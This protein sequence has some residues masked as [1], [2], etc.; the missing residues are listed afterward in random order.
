MVDSELELLKLEE[1]LADPEEL[2]HRVSCA[3]LKL[4]DHR[5]LSQSSDH[6]TSLDVLRGV[7]SRGRL[8]GSLDRE[9]AKTRLLLL[10]AMQ[11]VLARLEGG[12]F[13][14]VV[15][16]VGLSWPQETW[17]VFSRAA[18]VGDLSLG[19]AIRGAEARLSGPTSSPK[20]PDQGGLNGK[21]DSIPGW[22]WDVVERE[23]PL[24]N[25]KRVA[26]LL[27]LSER[28][29]RRLIRTGEIAS[30][31]RAGS[32]SKVL[33]PRRAVA[34]YLARLGTSYPMGEGS[35]IDSSPGSTPS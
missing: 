12:G 26:E 15:A 9:T 1:L 19:D 21:S 25:C 24:I 4:L 17:F 34:L 8:T 32:S 20:L 16:R 27:H 14:R 2:E 5:L 13:L 29:L 35:G 10:E 3:V 23:T 18:I 31:R 6:L 11:A 28:H 33:V 7:D 22:T 30:I